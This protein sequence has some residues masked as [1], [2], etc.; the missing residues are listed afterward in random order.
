MK[1][2]ILDFDGTIADTK[3]SIVNTIQATGKELGY[4]I[5]KE[6]DIQEKIGLPLKDTF[7]SVLKVPDSE[8]DNA[9]HLYRRKYQDICMESVTLF[10]NVKS[11]IEYLSKKGIVITVASSKGKE[12][13]HLLLDHLKVSPFIS[14]IYGE[15][16]V[17]NKKPAPDMAQL[18]LEQEKCEPEEALVVGD[19]VFDLQMGRSAGCHTCGVTYG[20]NSYEELKAQNPTYIINDFGELKSIFLAAEGKEVSNG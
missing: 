6:K 17:K 10:P 4:G 19:T 15:Q 9:I 20:N 7:S 3:S 1:L 5:A 14:C 18:I 8:I 11:T 12:A 16:D 13:L 2:L